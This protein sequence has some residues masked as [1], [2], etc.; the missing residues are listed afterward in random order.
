VKADAEQLPFED[1]SLDAGISTFT[2]SDF[3]DF[4]GAMQEALRVLKPGASFVYVGN[5]PCFVGATQEHLATGLPTL[6]PGYRR[7]GVWKSSEAPGAGAD[8]WRACLGTFVHVPLG[9]F[10]SAF[11]GFTLVAAEE[12]DD[13]W[14][15]PKTV[16][17]AL[18]KP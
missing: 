13:D 14:E 17:L 12:L 3:D 2:H 11:G 5:H 10:L 7:A 6:H 1:D 9:V 18:R 8:G 16:A 15:Y 4:G